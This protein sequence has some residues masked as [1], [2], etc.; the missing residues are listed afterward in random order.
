MN[1]TLESH[2]LFP[3][4]AWILVIG[5]AIFTYMLTVRVQAELTN[6]GDGIAR[7]EER[8]NELDASK[9]KAQ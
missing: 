1:N 9:V 4:V 6:I 7:L 5:F 8:L 2:K 3:V